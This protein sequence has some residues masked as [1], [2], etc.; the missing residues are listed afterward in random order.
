MPLSRSAPQTRIATCSIRLLGVH[1]D[2]AEPATAEAVALAVERL[3]DTLV[4]WHDAV[5][6]GAPIPA[7]AS[8]ARPPEAATTAGLAEVSLSLLER[9]SATARSTTREL[10]DVADEVCRHASAV[11]AG[12]L[13][14]MPAEV[15][16]Q[17]ADQGRAIAESLHLLAESIAELGE[18]AARERHRTPADLPRAA[19]VLS[20]AEQTVRRTASAAGRHTP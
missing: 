5:V 2:A 17:V 1:L 19:I 4:S 20:R 12:R 8:G 7:R 16:E 10:D 13:G 11:S 3:A 15:A 18:T 9:V 14:A 6:A